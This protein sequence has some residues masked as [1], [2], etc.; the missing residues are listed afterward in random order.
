MS[1]AEKQLAKFGWNQGE[2]LGK[3]KDGI[4]KSISVVKKNDTKGVS[5]FIL[6][7]ASRQRPVSGTVKSNCRRYH[8]ISYE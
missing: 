6:Q 5:L 3:N 8:T 1:F 7:L 2:G 4:K